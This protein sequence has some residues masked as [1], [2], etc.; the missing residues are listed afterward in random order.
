MGRKGAG[1]EKGGEKLKAQH[2]LRI[3]VGHEVER[4]LREETVGEDQL[5]PVQKAEKRKWMKTW[6]AEKREII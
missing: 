2:R 6:V 1:R 5:V 3:H 4:R